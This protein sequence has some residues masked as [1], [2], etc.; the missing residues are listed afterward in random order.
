MEFMVFVLY[1]LTGLLALEGLS[2]LLRTR[3][4]PAR[5]RNRHRDL[6]ERVAPGVVNISTERTITGHPL[7][8]F[9]PS[10]RLASWGSPR[11]WRA[12]DSSRPT[13]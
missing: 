2:A 11:S 4:D 10:P 8:E 6:A 1:F 7:E 13:S 5:V 3:A 12:A 9:F